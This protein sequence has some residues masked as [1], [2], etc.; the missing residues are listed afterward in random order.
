MKT[1]EE[2]YAIARKSHIG[3][4]LSAC[5]DFGKFYGFTFSP[6]KSYG[7]DVYATG[8]YMVAVDKETGNLSYY[9]ITSDSE[10]YSK[11]RKVDVSTI[12]D[13]TLEDLK[14]D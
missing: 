14:H 4:K 5:L 3:M 1:I 8:P 9:N 12:M 6:Y 7:R 13:K 2:C 10:L 11:A